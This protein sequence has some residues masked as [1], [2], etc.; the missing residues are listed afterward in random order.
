[1]YAS[2]ESVASSSLTLGGDSRTK[3]PRPRN[4][5]R[6]GK[7]ESVGSPCEV[8]NFD[9]AD[10]AFRSNEDPLHENI[11]IEPSCHGGLN[12]SPEQL[13]S[14]F[15]VLHGAVVSP[16]P[17]PPA[18]SAESP[19]SQTPTAISETSS[20]STTITSNTAPAKE[21]SISEAQ[22]AES[23]RKECARLKHTIE[24]ETAKKTKL[25]K[26]LE[27]LAVA[28]RTQMEDIKVLREE[29]AMLKRERDLL[30]EHESQHLETIGF[31]KTEL[32][33][34]TQKSVADDVS[35]E[36]EQLK[37]ENDLFATQIIENEV[38]LRTIQSEFGC[39]QREN[40]EMKQ[41][42]ESLQTGKSM[43]GSDLRQE[44]CNTS[45]AS[46]LNEL[47]VRLAVME[48]ARRTICSEE[49]QIKGSQQPLSRQ[50]FVE[51]STD[52]CGVTTPTVELSLTDE[53]GT[54]AN[55]EEET[56]STIMNGKTEDVELSLEGPLGAMS[57]GEAIRSNASLLDEEDLSGPWLC[58]CF[59][60][61]NAL[62]AAKGEEDRQP[63][64]TFPRKAESTTSTS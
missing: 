14:V 10:P 53:R 55:Y 50:I 2:D 23:L 49:S 64:P 18:P 25:K 20:A 6:K 51:S 63:P 52:T 60:A 38:E 58:D 39:L 5:V 59:P 21:E 7:G 12:L 45:L 44:S 13:G 27:A 48:T 11:V 35:P 54:K 46:K 28:T 22:G 47:E 43:D 36:V 17:P 30:R 31:L 8:E 34:V 33:T 1:M 3:K 62:L 16:P 26:S 9:V 40:S 32:D 42:L 61:R 4:E 37:I 19:R 15:G 24:C 41:E 57:R 29:V 56:S